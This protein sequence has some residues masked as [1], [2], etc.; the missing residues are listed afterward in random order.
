MSNKSGTGS[1]TAG[2]VTGAPNVVIGELNAVIGALNAV[3]G[4]GTP[5][6]IV[7]T[8]MITT[9]DGTAPAIITVTG[10]PNAQA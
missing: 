4:E 5:G 3:I 2:I 9:T 8:T 10:G 7:T 6:G 1:G